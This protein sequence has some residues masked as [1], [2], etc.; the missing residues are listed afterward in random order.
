MSSG[1]LPLKGVRVLDLSRLLPGPYAS[2]V[3]ADLGADVV[4]I[5]EPN[6]GDY[7]R[8]M[9]P[10]L[11]DSDES[12]LFYALNRNKR[13]LVLDLK[14]E[15]GAGALRRL[16]PRADVLLESFRPGVMDRLGLGFPAL[17]ALNPKLIYCAISGFGQS[18]P[19]AMK[20]GHDLTYL[21][22]SGV[23]GYGGQPKGP[24]ALPGG[25]MA[26]L[27]GSL[28]SLVGIL[29]ALHERHQSGRG[30]LIDI[31]MTEASLAFIH[32][33][34]GARLASG[35]GAPPLSRGIEALNGGYACYRAYRTQD[36]RYLAVGALEPKFLSGVLE[37]LGR[38]ELL[39]ACY[40]SGEEGARAHRELEAAFAGRTLSEWLEVFAGTDLCVEPV[41]EGDEVL[42]DPQ[43][44]ARGAF[45]MSRDALRAREVMH[46]RTP[47]TPVEE[48]VEPPP[49][50]GQHSREVLS[51][52]GF[53][54]EEMQRLGV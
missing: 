4:K 52:A 3:L 33:S 18:G 49:T 27:G 15:A 14:S 39:S 1:S 51:E 9:P 29:A 22:R 20:A 30:R 8:H 19:D 54:E 12:A 6:G 43:L 42:E 26:D 5:E 11:P 34:L 35:P 45:L 13:S 31:S 47:L 10:L 48:Q 36:G 24:V 41:R 2:M 40:A 44:V 17:S 25:Q 38:E 28:F 7:L 23:L 50:L 32:M 37:R 46:V 21:A 53:S 16:V